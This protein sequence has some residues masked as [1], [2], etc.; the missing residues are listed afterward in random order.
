MWVKRE[1]LET[2][3]QHVEDLMRQLRLVEDRPYLID[4]QRDGRKTKFIFTRRGKVF[5]IETMSLM[6]D[7]MKAWKD[8][9]L[10]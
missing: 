4:I 5:E 1:Q 3:K 8:D 10:R 7:N 6:S 2:M 9:L